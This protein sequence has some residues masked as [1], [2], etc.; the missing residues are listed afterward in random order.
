MNPIL[1]YYWPAILWALF[2]FTLCTIH[3]GT[4]TQS[5]MF[6]PGFD[7]LVHCGFFFVFVIFYSQ[8]LIRK[9]K[10][11]RFPYKYVILILLTAIFYGYAIEVLQKYVFTW[12]DFEWNDV[13]ADS[14]GAFMGMFSVLIFSAAFNHDK[15]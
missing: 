2:I 1:K 12:R 5:P 4:I 13:F 10:L 7:K 9:H 6:F 8:G 11:I 15:K 3:L 14:V